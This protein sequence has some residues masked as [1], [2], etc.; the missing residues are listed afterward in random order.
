MSKF[1]L[2]FGVILCIIGFILFGMG[3]LIAESEPGVFAI[4]VTL[5]LVVFI[6]GCL[7]FVTYKR[8]QEKKQ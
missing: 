7:A 2:Y 5:G 6:Y 8:E 4:L 1:N 3:C